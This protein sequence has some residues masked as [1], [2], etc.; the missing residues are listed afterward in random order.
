ME[1]RRNLSLLEATKYSMTPERT[2]RIGI[3]KESTV[4]HNIHNL[5]PELLHMICMYL[6]PKEVTG[7]RILDRTLAAV[8]LEY[9]VSQ[10]HLVA[11]PDS[12]DRLL[13][14]AEHPSARR[15]VTSLF[16]EADVLKLY[17]TP[18]IDRKRWEESI[19][20]PDDVGSLEEFQD[21]C[22]A[23]AY[24]RLPKKYVRRPLAVAS[25]RHLHYTK[26]ELQQAYEKYRSYRTEQRRMIRSVA[27]EEAL[28][29]AMKQLPRLKT[30]I[31]SCRR[32]LTN[33]FRT[34]FGAGLS[35]DVAP[36]YGNA[37]TVGAHQLSFILSAA[38]KAGLQIKKLVCGSLGQLF[39]DSSFERLE[40]MKRSI[41]DLR[42]LHLFLT[43][44]S[45]ETNP[46]YN[47]NGSDSNGTASI[48]FASFAPSLEILSVRFDEDHPTDLPD[49]RHLIKDFHWSFL[50]SAS[51]AKMQTGFE[52][53]IGFCVRHAGTLKD[54]N[55]TDI[56]LYTD[57]WLL[58]FCEMREKLGLKIMTVAGIF[59]SDEGEYWDFEAGNGNNPMKRMV[60][61]YILHDD[62]FERD[63]P[64]TIFATKYVL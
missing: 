17:R 42:C 5:P 33:H 59:Q 51:F 54:F 21:P 18:Q 8:G 32:G 57:G 31:L 1:S 50:A 40:A 35:E 3:L 11:K 20:V 10:I 53:L 48:S 58:M 12:F 28:V 45:R 46:G 34:A 2:E 55:L 27:Y 37:E 9:L 19:V 26:R 16:Y 44:T 14:V 47:P 30:I 56:R 49:L 4:G 29:G 62:P 61:R 6:E 38:D 23:S 60:E 7:I 22:F 43:Y 52:T 64:Y 41:H 63:L 25:T 24:D 15:Y 13:A 39:L 36:D